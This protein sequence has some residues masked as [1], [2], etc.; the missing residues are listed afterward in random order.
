[1]GFLNKAS[2]SGGG[3]SE[4]P[5]RANLSHST[6]NQ[7]HDSGL[8]SRSI[9]SINTT[10]TLNNLSHTTP[11]IIDSGATDHITTSIDLFFK[12]SE[13][14]PLNINLPNGSIVQAHFSGS[15]QLSPDFVIHDVLFVPNFSFNLLSLPKLLLT[16]PCRVIFSNQF[17]NILCQIQ[18]MNTLKM[19]GSA[20]LKEGLFHL[21]IGKER[22]SSTNNAT[23][24]PINNSNLWHFRLGH[25]SSNR[26]NVLNQ[27]F[28]FISKHSNEVCD[29]CHFAK[30]KKL[31]YSPSSSRVSKIFDLIHMD[32]WGPFSKAS[33]HGHKYF[34]TIL[35]DFS[36]YTWVVLLKSKSEVKTHVHNFINLVENQYETK[37]KCIRSDN[38]PEF[39]LRDFF[40]SKGIIHQTSCVYTPQQNGRVER[41]HQHILNVA[42]ALMFQSKLPSNFWSYAIKHAIFLINR[43]PSPIIS[44]K[45]P[46]ELLNKIPP[47][48]SML[49]VFGCL[50]YAST[51][52]QRHKFEPRSRKG[53]FMG[54]QNGTKGFV[55]LDI[56][57][58]EIL[59]SRNVIFHETSFP[60]HTSAPT[61]PF[62]TQPS[63]TI[64]PNPDILTTP[65]TSPNDT[66]PSQNPNPDASASP[67]SPAAPTSPFHDSISSYPTS[68]DFDIVPHH[69]SSSPAIP[70][71]RRSERD[72]HP[73]P[74]LSEYQYKLPSLKSV[75]SSTRS[76]QNPCWR[77]AMTCEL[78]ALELNH[79][80]DVVETPSHVRPI[81]CKWVFKIKRLPNGSIERYKARLV[82][83]G[84]SQIEGIDY[85]ETFSPVVK[86]TTVR[87]VLALASI[88]QWHIQQLDVS[89]AFLHGDLLED[90]YM[91]LPQGLTGYSS[92]HSCKLRK[93]L[94]GLKQ[95]SRK[96]YE[97]LSNLLLSN[98][99]KQAHSD[100]SLFTKRHGSAFT[101]LL[102][103]VDDIVL[104]GNSAAE[105]TRIKHILHSNFHVKDLGQLKYFLGIEVAHSSKGISLCQ[106]KYCLDLLSDS[107]MLGCKPSS[108]PMDSTLRLHDDASGYLDDPLPYR[109]L[110]GRLV[111]LT[112]TRPDIAFSTQQLS[113]FMSKPTNAHHAAAMRVLR[114]LKSCPGTGLFFPR[115]CPIQVSGFSDADW[116]TC[117]ASR[118]SITGY[119]FFIGNA[120]ISWKTKKQT[121]V[122]RS[123]SEAEYRALASATCELQW[124]IYLLRDLHISL[125]QISL[126]YC[127]NTSALHIAANPVFHERTKHLDIDCHI[128]RE[129]TQAGLMKLLP[130]PSAK[131][132][133]D[134]FTKALPP[135]AFKL[136]LSKLQLQ[137][138]FAP[139]ACGGLTAEPYNSTAQIT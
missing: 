54:F 69:R 75:Q 18:D 96:W 99:Y 83:K 10:H 16:A 131:Q 125:S 1:M 32:I 58:R 7:S 90:V 31:S 4:T 49:K 28:P 115:V 95:S 17:S 13:I 77:E 26:L 71:P 24:T 121:T 47:D 76:I 68:T 114:Y 50:C 52:N 60:F 44:H 2:G 81:G 91:E 72:I 67:S 34:L 53:I 48:F 74:Y 105:I 124:I 104:T 89:N 27:Q 55:I 136:N 59:V 19:I 130:V 84:Y 103:Y 87:V 122:S 116:A 123:S 78:K 113:Q 41:K 73:P 111:Y 57:T 56:N 82:A 36:R 94:Y 85:F 45:T 43:V 39:F 61:S 126:L 119:C 80:W 14:K 51:H 110:V 112:N 106:R 98:G 97:K 6:P 102:I 79:T 132:L 108:T 46:F 137:N 109:R 66:S 129:K 22:R 38:G 127:D 62:I 107:G 20:N 33:I 88:N 5:S 100:H 25:L 120:L 30:Q 37:V 86:M 65:P 23:A 8:G 11:W 35:D 15:I 3:S 128:V 133:A 40:N 63:L 92:S 64:S 134:I 117:V 42:R 135:H 118:R 12:Y 70:P 21:D 101:A 9:F 29:V 139:P 93:S 138:I